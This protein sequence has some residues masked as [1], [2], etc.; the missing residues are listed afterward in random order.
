MSCE[1]VCEC[2][3]VVWIFCMIWRCVLFSTVACSVPRRWRLI[4]QFDIA[5]TM[6]CVF[7]FLSVLPF[8]FCNHFSSFH[9]FLLAFFGGACTLQSSV[10]LFSPKIINSLYVEHFMLRW[11]F[12]CGIARH[13]TTQ[14]TRHTTNGAMAHA[15][16]VLHRRAHLPHSFCRSI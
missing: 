12:D 2:E 1:C 13:G 9:S 3:C 4:L 16:R 11:A 8:M 7:A 15:H 10:K 14:H 6:F 5:R